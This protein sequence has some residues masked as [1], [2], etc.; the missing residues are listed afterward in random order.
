[1]EFRWERG[2]SGMYNNPASGEPTVQWD[3]DVH[4]HGE[5]KTP[6]HICPEETYAYAHPEVDK[7]AMSW[8]DIH[9]S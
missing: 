9:V 4:T 7:N 6:M 8:K 3:L 5:D 2:R 1:M